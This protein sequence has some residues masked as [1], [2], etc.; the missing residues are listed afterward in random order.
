MQRVVITGMGAVCGNGSSVPEIWNNLCLGIAH[1]SPISAFDVRENPAA[2]STPDGLITTVCASKLTNRE[3]GEKIGLKG[4]RYERYDRH[5]LFAFVAAEEAM[6]HAGLTPGSYDS[7]RSRIG[8][9][10]GTGDGGLYETYTSTLRIREGKAIMPTANLREL[11]NLFAGYLAQKYGLQVPNHVHCTACAASAHAMQ[12]AA[13]LI[14]LGRAD[15]VV[16]G[17]AE[18]VISPFGIGSFAAQNALANE[19]R[20]YQKG[21]RGFL[22]GEGA[23]VLVFENYDHAYFRGATILAEVAGYGA[24]ADGD[25]QS[26]ITDP[27]LYGGVRAAREALRMARCRPETIDYVNT[28]GTGTPKG[29]PVEINGLREIAGEYAESLAISSTKSFTGHLLGAAGALEAIL[30]VQSI[31]TGTVLPTYGLT[32]ENLDPDCGGVAHVMSEPLRKKVE[33]VLSNSFGFGGTNAS[34]LFRKCT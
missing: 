31:L 19:S 1:R 24:S 33:T 12:H 4:K 18:A 5:Q 26:D 9:A 23:A 3:L 32:P 34:M 21:R 27:G 28:H 22:M 20:P 2:Y 8:C 15:V 17:G 14:K 13:D 11:P 25:P 7:Y 6:L 29:D 10:M 16:T 30:S